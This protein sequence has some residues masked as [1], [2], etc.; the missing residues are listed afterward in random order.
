MIIVNGAQL[1]NGTA[2]NT[3]NNNRNSNNYTH[4]RLE[5]TQLPSYAISSH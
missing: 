4:D 1:Q 3:N 2:S 5:Q